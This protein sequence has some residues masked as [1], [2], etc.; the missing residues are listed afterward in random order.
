MNEPK[1]KKTLFTSLLIIAMLLFNSSS[2]VHAG[3]LDKTLKK[4]LKEQQEKHLAEKNQAAEASKEEIL[5]NSPE[6]KKLFGK[7][8]KS[9]S[10]KIVSK[11][12]APKK[13]SEPAEP[14]SIEDMVGAQSAVVLDSNSEKV[15]FSRNAFKKMAPASLTKIMTAVVV[16]E[17]CDNLDKIVT[18][19]HNI[20]VRSDGVALGLNA[21]DTTTLEELLYMAMLYSANDACIA[22]AEEVGGSVEDFAKI[23][24][25]KAK[26]IG[27]VNSNFVNPNGMPNSQHYSNAYDIALIS[28]YAMKNVKFAKIVG[29]KNKTVHIYGTKEVVKKNKKLKTVTKQLVKYDRTIKLTNRHKLLGKV[30][31]V[32]GIKTGYTIAAGRCLATSYSEGAKDL[33]II[34]LKSKDVVAD[35][36]ALLKYD[37]FPQGSSIAAAKTDMKPEMPASL[38]GATGKIN[39]I[40][41]STITRNN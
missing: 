5:N 16:L 36:M 30:E 22:I 32:R 1:S 13:N 31:G 6:L 4:L 41:L 18:I 15:L 20:R 26:D 23:M 21:G 35:T 25:S 40:T 24:N 39:N 14:E 19:K 12:R 3:E 27:A 11:K 8:D 38:N 33:I 37:K 17:A 7:I 2:T 29:T 9:I 10:K 34:I 28:N